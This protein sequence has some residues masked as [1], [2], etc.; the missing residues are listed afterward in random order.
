MSLEFQKPRWLETRLP[1][2]SR[3][4]VIQGSRQSGKTTLARRTWPTLRYVNLDAPDDR[5][6][7][8]ALRTAAWPQ[9]VGDAILDEAQKEPS[10]FEKVKHAFD[11]GAIRFTVLLGSSRFLMLRQVQET[12][13]GR[14]F[15]FD[16]W[17]LMLSELLGTS[18]S[19][20]PRPL[21]AD[22]LKAASPIDSLLRQE[23]E[24][25]LGEEEDRRLAALEHLETWGGMPGLLALSTEE[26]RD[27]LRSY[28]RTFVERDL[29]DLA[30][31]PDLDPFR[32]LEQL[33]MLRSGHLLSYAE[34]ARDAGIAPSTAREYL[35]YLRL[36]YQVILLR[37]YHTN[38]TSTVIKTPRLYWADLGLLRQGTMHWGPA[39]GPLF[40]GLVVLE[41]RKWID[42]MAA[43]ARLFFY[44][45]RGGLEVDLLVETPNGILGIE[46]KHRPTA[47]RS[48]ATGLA[49]LAAALGP[50][51]LGGLVVTR[52]G[53]LAPLRPE[54]S[55]WSVPAHRLF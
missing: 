12:L 51:W 41:C 3:I 4:A 50:R 14:A 25:L 48:D 27:W 49:A 16:L 8:R 35:H 31:L 7:L 13:A 15:V 22:L 5:A 34:L 20:P 30:R 45:T 36:S 6:A 11:A 18:G 55:I 38:L 10:V 52:G 29:V 26:R 21:F 54:A 28:Q 53:S 37:P 32:S 42:T 23:P 44:R 43:D 17:P 1:A 47:V 40:E 2:A 39:T 19:P 9:A 46:V 33:A 24:A